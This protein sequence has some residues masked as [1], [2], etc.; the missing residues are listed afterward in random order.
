[1]T[2]ERAQE[3]LARSPELTAL[4]AGLGDEP[5]SAAAFHARADRF[6]AL[7]AS[8]L[9]RD[10]IG[11]ELAALL[12]SPTRTIQ[13]SFHGVWIVA[14]DRRFELALVATSEPTEILHGSPRHRLIGVG[15]PGSVELELFA[16]SQ[17][18]P[19]DVF[20]RSLT[21]AAVGTRSL[22][23]GEVLAQRAWFD[24]VE[25]TA[26][27]PG[28]LL[29]FAS[30]PVDRLRW[31]YERAT[32]RPLRPTPTDLAIHHLE[33]AI[34]TL[35]HLG[36]PDAVEV[37]A[38]LTSCPAHHVRWSAIRAVTELDPARG[39][40]LLAAALTDPHPHV[41]QAARGGLARL[42]EAEQER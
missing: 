10:L 20:D 12:A 40:E 1:M 8:S 31:T 24:V 7:L 19:G 38:G 16:H 41:R 13:D 35:L 6:A 42:L 18:H 3:R 27:A 39:R 25:P 32:L 37:L 30:A 26:R 9:L 21:L 34:G 33:Y 22:R 29:I 28:H 2:P 14:S 23:A 11:D 5:D 4:V 36:D 17:P 15:L